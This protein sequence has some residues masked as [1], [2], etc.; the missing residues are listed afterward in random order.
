MFYIEQ[1]NKIVLFDTDRQKLE[2]TLLFTPQYAGLEIQ[3]TQEDYTIIDFKLITIEEANEIELNK[4]K[5]TKVQ[6]NDTVRDIALNQG[7]TYKDVLFDSD[8]DQKINLLATIGSMSDEDVTTWFGMDNQ[9]LECTKEDLFN[10]GGLISQLHTF[11]W[12]KNAEIKAEIA[13]AETL[14]E[15][16]A[17]EIS[18]ELATEE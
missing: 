14:E 7:V 3:E 16:E 9:P 18:Y 4:A 17:I 11:C 13:E 10:I 6:E 1:N 15:L 8:T 5:Q 2:N 12:T